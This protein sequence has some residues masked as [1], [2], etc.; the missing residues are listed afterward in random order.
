MCHNALVKV[1]LP[2]AY[3]VGRHQR[4][5][6]RGGRDRRLDHSPAPAV[7]REQPCQVDPCS[8][9]EPERGHYGHAA[10]FEVAQV[11]FVRV[12]AQHL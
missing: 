3:S 12:P 11:A 8:L 2:R 6:E 1:P 9:I 4:R 10:C 7:L 5:A